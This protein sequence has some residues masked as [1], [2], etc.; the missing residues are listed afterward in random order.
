MAAPLLS[1]WSFQLDGIFIGTTR[2]RE[3]RN[4]MM[5]SLVG[6]ITVTLALVQF[7]GNHG[8][9]AGLLVFMIL[10][11]VTLAYCYPALERAAAAPNRP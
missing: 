1:V 4:A 3:M 6:F 9:W 11:A 10:R 7:A 8:L 2:T 5:L